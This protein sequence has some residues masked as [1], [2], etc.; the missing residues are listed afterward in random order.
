MAPWPLDL[1]DGRRR[2]IHTVRVVMDDTVR[3]RLRLVA[4]YVKPLMRCGL[5]LDIYKQ[6]NLTWSNSGHHH[7]SRLVRR[8]WP[9]D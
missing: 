2:L 7:L 5:H 3:H 6:C 1:Y 4:M 8:L 9:Y